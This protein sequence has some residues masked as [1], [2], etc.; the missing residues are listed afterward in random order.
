[1]YTNEQKK[2]AVEGVCIRRM[3]ASDSPLPKIV[4]TRLKRLGEARECI[5]I[6]IGKIAKIG[7]EEA[8]ELKAFAWTFF[9]ETRSKRGA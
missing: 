9:R 2:V 1:M 7:R 3:I 8:K 4:I 6:P 5:D